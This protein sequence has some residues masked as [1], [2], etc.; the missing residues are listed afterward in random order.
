MQAKCSSCATLE[1]LMVT[2]QSRKVHLSPISSVVT[3]LVALNRDSKCEQKP[4]LEPRL[5][6]VS[7]LY[8]I[9]SNSGWYCKL[10]WIIIANVENS[11][12][13]DSMTKVYK[14]EWRKKVSH[15]LCFNLIVW[16][17]EL[18]PICLSCRHWHGCGLVHL[19]LLD[20]K[21]CPR[22]PGHCICCCDG[23]STSWPSDWCV[24][25]WF[26]LTNPSCKPFVCNIC[27]TSQKMCPHESFLF[28]AL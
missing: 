28:A 11:A 20:Q 16:L 27:Q 14:I 24:L 6:H 21:H 5:R 12:C 9:S 26:L 10:V 13:S 19:W 2:Q 23:M 17:L 3:G 1:S 8:I 7:Q 18:S 25:F 4:D 15:S 22:G